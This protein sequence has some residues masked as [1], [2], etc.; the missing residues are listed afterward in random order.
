MGRLE[1][2]GIVN[3]TKLKYTLDNIHFHTMAEH[4]IEGFQY[5]IEMHMVHYLDKSQYN[6]T[7]NLTKL[8]IGVIFQNGNVVNELLEEFNLENLEVLL[9]TF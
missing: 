8:V 9:I 6:L 5:S 3:G 7:N 1:V 4:T 2:E